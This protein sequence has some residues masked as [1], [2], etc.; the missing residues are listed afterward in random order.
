MNKLDNLILFLYDNK[1]DEFIVFEKVDENY[2]LIFSYPVEQNIDFHS[3][4][5]KKYNY[6]TLSIE[7]T[8]EL[9]ILYKV[10]DTKKSYIIDLAIENI[11]SHIYKILFSFHT[12]CYNLSSIAFKTL[13]IDFDEFI[14][15]IYNAINNNELEYTFIYFNNNIHKFEKF[16]SISKNG[17][18]TNT[19]PIP[20]EMDD[21][22]NFDQKKFDKKIKHSFLE[23]YLYFPIKLD[24]LPGIKGIIIFFYKDDS[25]Y[26]LLCKRFVFR[27]NLKEILSNLIYFYFFIK[28]QD[29]Y[30]QQL[31][32]LIYSKKEEIKDKN[33][34]ILKQINELTQSEKAKS[35]L[36]TDVYH[37]LLTPLNSIVG[38]SMYLINFNKHKLKPEI[39]ESIYSIEGNSYYL[40]FFILNII[41]YTKHLSN[42]FKLNN[43]NFLFLLVTS[44]FKRILT[45]FK[46]THNLKITIN[47]P[48]K[49]F[50]FYS[51]KN[52]IQQ[53]I[54]SLILFFANTNSPP[55]NFTIKQI[56]SNT[57]YNIKSLVF[58]F[59]FEYTKMYE[60]NLGKIDKF[61]SKNI[62][63]NTE[64]FKLE[65]FSL[66]VSSILLRELKGTF[67]IEKKIDK[68][69]IIL[70]IPESKNP[71][72]KK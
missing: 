29:F 63:Y 39:L 26:N 11:K 34:K 56:N 30:I 9:F 40:Y 23:K 44:Q 3:L 32:K 47:M 27:K 7:K 35:A 36:F 66:F 52:A 70:K 13:F 37:H 19:A 5:L 72:F 45:F 6:K 49:D 1:I 61:F 58:N 62:Y 38:F 8:I 10:K 68:I 2:D 48:G 28:E 21:I 50:Y 42:S 17:N 14:Q 16:I 41:T 25:I 33:V 24:T 55:I 51:D 15:K 69:N 60:Q 54:F 18:Y 31:E 20:L 43:E 64:S 67:K 22:I 46:T 65:T 59:S 71:D 12:I 4:N 53:I 57:K